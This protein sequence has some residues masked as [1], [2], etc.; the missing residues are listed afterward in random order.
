M[1]N[2]KIRTTH[3]AASPL[4]RSRPEGRR[5]LKTFKAA[6]N[7][8]SAYV[9][10]DVL[11]FIQRQALLAG[12][13][14]A[15][16]L[17]AGRICHDPGSGPYTLVMAAGEARDGEFHCSPS[18]VRLLPLGHTRLRRR[19]AEAHPDREI[20]GWYHTH[21]HY[22]PR[23]SHVDV[24]EQ[25]N[26]DDPNQIGIVYGTVHNGEPF[27]V[28]QGPRANL[29]QSIRVA[30][31]LFEEQQT[32]VLREAETKPTQNFLTPRR[33]PRA[34]E[35]IKT[36]PAARHRRRYS[37][38]EIAVLSAIAIIWLVQTFAQSLTL[39]RLAQRISF[40]EG[41]LQE[42]SSSRMVDDIRENAA[43]PSSTPATTPG[44]N[45]PSP[46]ASQTTETSSAD[47][48]KSEVEPGLLTPVKTMS[49]KITSR[50]QRRKQE[51]ATSRRGGGP[52]KKSE[53]ANR[54]RSEIKPTV[55]PAGV[56]SQAMQ[57][58]PT[59]ISPKANPRPT[60]KPD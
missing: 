1:A 55:R 59:V 45:S 36:E 5:E 14:E 24:A 30:D 13:N 40:A 38:L 18:F 15:I 37:R 47:T 46:T 34:L 57:T 17:L 23:F 21:P 20:V 26:W 28:Y 50:R 31:R 44:A 8:F 25:R 4:I 10:S 43:Q 6:D 53:T 60:L 27:G 16:G 51:A 56:K 41:R 33:E 58:Q 22:R 39:F 2:I 12:D 49:P 19:L 11:D 35:E 32:D 7:S 29:L 54:N 3:D 52:R 48:T 42:L 9:H